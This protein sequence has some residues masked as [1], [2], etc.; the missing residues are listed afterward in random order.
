MKDYYPKS[1]KRKLS[2]DIYMRALFSIRALPRL[3]E[4]AADLLDEEYKQEVHVQTSNKKN[5]PTEIKAIRREKT[6]REIE[7]VEKAFLTIPE[8]YRAMIMNNIINQMPME[9]IVGASTKTLSRMRMKV[10]IE[11]AHNTGLID[12]YE[13]Q[14]ARK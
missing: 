12:D 10:I 4:K 8:E 11:V 7:Q 5:S 3:K 14:E 1:I 9:M 2:K 6:L 13:Y